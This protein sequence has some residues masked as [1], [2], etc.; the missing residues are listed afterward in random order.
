MSEMYKLNNNGLN[1]DPC[2]IPMDVVF[3]PIKFPSS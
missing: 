1:G 2:G 3:G